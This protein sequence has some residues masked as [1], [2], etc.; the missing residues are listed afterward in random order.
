MDEIRKDIL[1]SLHSFEK[2]GSE[3]LMSDDLV[4]IAEVYPAIQPLL[5]EIEFLRSLVDSLQETVEE[6][7]RKLELLQNDVMNGLCSEK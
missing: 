7:G 4:R 1:W 5:E 3:H 6:L 2:R